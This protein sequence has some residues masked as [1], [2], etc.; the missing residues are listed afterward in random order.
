MMAMT[1]PPLEPS[2]G[3]Q[4][5]GD[6]Y[7]RWVIWGITF[8][9]GLFLLLLLGRW[10]FGGGEAAAAVVDGTAVT[11]GPF[12]APPPQT[13]TGPSTNSLRLARSKYRATVVTI[14]NTAGTATVQMEISCV[15]APTGPI[16]APVRGSSTTLAVEAV[17]MDVTYPGCEY[18]VN[19][20]ACAGCSLNG[21]FYSL[22]EIQ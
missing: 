6:P 22:P 9:I 1:T 15:P 4:R 14:W 12:I 2:G 20:T 18:R 3:P 10:L 8:L 7:P 11:S 13:T 16:W 19:V 21:Y 17:A 5:S